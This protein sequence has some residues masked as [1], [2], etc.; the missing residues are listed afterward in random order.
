MSPADADDRRWRL[1]SLKA[2]IAD[3]PRTDAESYAAETA[4]WEGAELTDTPA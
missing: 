4:Q 1:Q 3:T 2:A